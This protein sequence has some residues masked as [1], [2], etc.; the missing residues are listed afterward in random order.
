MLRFLTCI[1]NRKCGK[2][3]SPLQFARA[4][5]GS[6]FIE[7]VVAFPLF[8]ISLLVVAEIGR[9]YYH[10]SFLR[11]GVSRAAQISKVDERLGFSRIQ[12]PQD[13]IGISTRLAEGCRARGNDLVS[14]DQTLNGVS[15]RYSPDAGQLAAFRTSILEQSASTLA[16]TN[17]DVVYFV[18]SDLS[19][20]NANRYWMAPVGP[21]QSNQVIQ[22][23][24]QYRLSP[25]SYIGKGIVEQFGI[26]I[27]DI[28]FLCFSYTVTN[29]T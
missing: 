4:Q 16:A 12:I 15:A 8:L 18:H 24:G 26:P 3:R 28:Y 9:I 6:V 29:E 27:P 7:F 25:F 20:F 5:D 10:D 21:T 14:F 19:D 1:T 13:E 2:Q 23:I 17:L 11:L 22:L